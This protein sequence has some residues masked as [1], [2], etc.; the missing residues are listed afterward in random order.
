[1]RQTKKKINIARI[2]ITGRYPKRG[3]AV[4]KKVKELVYVESGKGLVSVNGV[5]TPLNKGDVV[6]IEENELVWWEG[7][8]TLIISCAPAW[9][10]DQYEVLSC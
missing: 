2:E 9:T 3:S 5:A 7:K 6:F 1:M 4:N 10:K 8:M